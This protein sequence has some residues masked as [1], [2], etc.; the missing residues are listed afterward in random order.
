MY[1]YIYIYICKMTNFK[2][3]VCGKTS[4]GFGK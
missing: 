2:C 4:E 1:I 3:K